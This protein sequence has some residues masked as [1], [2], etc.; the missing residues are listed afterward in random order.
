MLLDRDLICVTVSRCR[1]RLIPT[2]PSDQ[3]RYTKFLMSGSGASGTRKLDFIFY[4]NYYRYMD[5]AL[6]PGGEGLSI[7]QVLCVSLSAAH[8]SDAIHV[9]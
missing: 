9:L 4:E 5:D 1:N 3:R 7:I 6:A 8:Q 2:P